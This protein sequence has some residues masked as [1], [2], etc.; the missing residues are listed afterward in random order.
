MKNVLFI[1][2]FYPPINNSGIFRALKFTKYL[3]K[4]KKWNPIVLTINSNLMENSYV[5]DEFKEEIEDI[6]VHYV[7]TLRPTAESTQQYREIYREAHIPDTEYGSIMHYVIKGL[8]LIKENNID[9]IYCTIPP[10]SIG[11]VGALLKDITNLPLIVDYRDGW[12]TGNEF[13]KY[14]TEIGAEL[15]AYFE[16]K[17]QSK[18]DYLI[19]VDKELAREITIANNISVITNGF[20]SSDFKQ[21]NKKIYSNEFIYYGGFLY[22][23]YEESVLK[24]IEALKEINKFKKIDLIICGK[25]QTLDFKKKIEEYDFVKYL[26]PISYTESIVYSMSAAINLA[27][28][29]LEFSVG[30]KYY[31]LIPAKR[32]ILSINKLTNEF[33]K[34][35]LAAY[36]A[37]QILSLDV[38]KKMLIE[39]IQYL[40]EYKEEINIDRFYNNYERQNLT[41]ALEEIFDKV[42]KINQKKVDD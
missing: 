24:V 6:E 17:M 36:P 40:L 32:P 16:Q 35:F 3:K 9:L 4:N 39:S 5:N 28:Y 26:G 20:D 22:K 1:T 42:Y 7:D 30:S 25:I 18:V 8:K 10:Y 37:K 27:V 21:K 19:T 14:R 13:I 38:S 41:L 29:T 2:H 33:L 12:T 11:I 15:N 31:N 23:E 34:E